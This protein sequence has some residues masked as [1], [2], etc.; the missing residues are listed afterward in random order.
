[1]P[2]PIGVVIAGVASGVGKTT[3]TL[4]LLAAL[5]RRGRA[6]QAFKV[7]PD[8]IDPGFHALA[9][10]RSSWNLDGFMLGGEQVVETF[11]RRAADADVCVV[12]GVMGCF[13]GRCAESEQ[14]STAEIAK[15]LGLPV[16]LVVDVGAQARSA[17]AVVRGF[18][19]FDPDL[20]I[21]GVILNRVGGERHTREVAAAIHETCAARVFGA[22]PWDADVAIPERHLG[23]VTAAEGPMSVTALARLAGMIERG[24]DVDALLASMRSAR[25]GQ[26]SRGADGDPVPRRARIGVARDAAFQFYYAD[27]LTRLAEAGAEI[28]GWSPLADTTLP[29]VDGLYV[30]G[31]Y[32]EVHAAR[33]AANDRMRRAVRAF[34]AGGGPIYA[35]CGGLMYLAEAIEDATG[36]V[37]PMVGLLPSTVRMRPPRL[38]LDYASVRL[39]HDTPLGAAGARARGHEFHASTLDPV[40][41]AVT[42]AYVVE[43][44]RGAHA[45]GYLIGRALMSY[46]HLHFG[47]NPDLATAFV[48]ACA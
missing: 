37:H 47:S 35:E 15:W 24:V 25:T 45:E 36:A 23:L 7:G 48:G 1:L 21:A 27:N 42:R 18:E 29:D 11:R 33:L 6:V 39:A 26:A 4:G 31:G 9:T 12:E 2:E 16:V 41:D 32:P 10:G 38:T 44:G 8:F 14:G 34:A 46:V 20:P 28:V 40:P 13:D 5:R 43:D 22:L 30:G 3:V 17:A 19:T